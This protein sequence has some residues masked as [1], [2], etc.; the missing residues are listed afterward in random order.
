VEMR[1][2][3]TEAV[4]E[5]DQFEADPIRLQQIVN[6]LLSNAAKFTDEGTITAKARL[7]NGSVVIAIEDSGFGIAADKLEIIF[8]RFRQ[9]DQSS[10]RKAGGTGLGLAITRQLV[11]M[12]GGDIWVESEVGKGTTF[13]FSIPLERP[14]EPISGD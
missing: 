10:T 13:S 9:A 7:D 1:V 4:R 3:V 5:L 8:E 2:E 6:N 12:H 14:Q 11:T